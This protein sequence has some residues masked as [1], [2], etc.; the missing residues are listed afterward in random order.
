MG[1]TSKGRFGFACA[2]R[3]R[4]DYE[5]VLLKSGEGIN[6]MLEWARQNPTDISRNRPWHCKTLIVGLKMDMYPAAHTAIASSCRGPY[7]FGDFPEWVNRIAC[8]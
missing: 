6:L 5:I 1:Y 2:C 7:F 4:V 3:E 8:L